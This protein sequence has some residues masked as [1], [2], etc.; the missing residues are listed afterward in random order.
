M[1]FNEKDATEINDEVFL[2]VLPELI[3]QSN[4]QSKLA[5]VGERNFF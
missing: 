3:L 5:L 4:V 2:E 1:N